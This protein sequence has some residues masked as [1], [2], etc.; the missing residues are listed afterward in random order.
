MMFLRALLRLP[1]D[2]T[3][4]G[5]CKLRPDQIHRRASNLRAP[6]DIPAFDCWGFTPMP[7]TSQV[8]I[9]MRPSVDEAW[10]PNW[11]ATRRKM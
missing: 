3:V 4:P 11:V 6:A 7:A 2:A 5:S 9:F 10:I 8:P 1:A